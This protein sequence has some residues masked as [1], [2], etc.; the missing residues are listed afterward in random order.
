MTELLVPLVGEVGEG[1]V[2]DGVV[3]EKGAARAAVTLPETEDGRIRTKLAKVTTIGNGAMT[4]RWLVLGDRLEL[5]SMSFS[6]EM[7]VHTLYNLTKG[8]TESLRVVSVRAVVND[9]CSFFGL[10]ITPLSHVTSLQVTDRH[11]DPAKDFPFTL[12]S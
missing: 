6:C 8:V 7:C 3:E 1:G 12:F 11:L 2:A 5:S 10:H 9:M 4:R